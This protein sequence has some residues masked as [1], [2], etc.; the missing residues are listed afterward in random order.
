MVN[1]RNFKKALKFSYFVLD[2]CFFFTDYCIMRFAKK[3]VRERILCLF[4]NSPSERIDLYKAGWML[5]DR[6]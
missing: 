5:D 3:N 2:L 6:C 1:S 4:I